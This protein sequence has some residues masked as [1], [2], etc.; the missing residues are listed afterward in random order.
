ML[1]KGYLKRDVNPVLDQLNNQQLFKAMRLIRNLRANA[2]HQNIHPA[3]T[4]A[5]LKFAL[6]ADSKAIRNSGKDPTFYDYLTELILIQLL[7]ALRE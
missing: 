4:R 7:E 5:A 1:E 3:L 6:Y 2:L